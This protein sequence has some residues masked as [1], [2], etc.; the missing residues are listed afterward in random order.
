VSR[1]PDR[2]AI[3]RLTPPADRGTETDRGRTLRT[4]PDS[5][6]FRPH[7]PGVD[8]IVTHLPNALRPNIDSAATVEFLLLKGLKAIEPNLDTR[9]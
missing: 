1:I 9:Q 8:N 7:I 3:R 2:V 4:L 6:I 5:V